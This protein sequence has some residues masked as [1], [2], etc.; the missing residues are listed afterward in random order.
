VF[1]VVA[2][3]S[4]PGEGEYDIGTLAAISSH[5]RLPD[6]RSLVSTRGSQRF[7]ILERRIDSDGCQVA[8]VE[9]VLDKDAASPDELAAEADEIAALVHAHFGSLPE[10][11]ESN[12]ICSRIRTFLQ[13]TPSVE[14]LF[15]YLK[16]RIRSKSGPGTSLLPYACCISSL[17]RL[18]T[19]YAL[20][21]QT[22]KNTHTHTALPIVEQKFG[23]LPDRDPVAFS[24]WVSSLL[25]ITLK[26]KQELLRI[27]STR[28]RL[29]MAV[30]L[31]K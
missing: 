30:V 11:I 29:A 8:M 4:N 17:S 19:I 18:R 24:F 5:V 20:T 21:P 14:Q 13:S 28:L 23:A 16:D 7:R 26:Q 27:S 1:G 25:P 15:S 9:R 31:C 22:N 6:G 3:P 10:S 2:T 12:E